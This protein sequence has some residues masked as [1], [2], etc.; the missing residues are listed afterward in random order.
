MVRA[1]ARRGKLPDECRPL[2]GVT[3]SAMPPLGWRNPV[4]VFGPSG[5][6]A[7]PCQAAQKLAD[8]PRWYASKS[9]SASRYE[10]YQFDDG[11]HSHDTAASYRGCV[12]REDSHEAA[13]DLGGLRGRDGRA[14]LK[15]GLGGDGSAMVPAHDLF[16]R[17]VSARAAL[18]AWSRS[19]VAS[20]ACEQGRIRNLGATQQS[21]T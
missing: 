19:K 2:V 16:V 13:C 1:A 11:R 21:S 20:E 7:S 10:R 6:L 18:H 9:A 14:R 15:R 3:P 12:L 17:F 5:G 8:L 4:R